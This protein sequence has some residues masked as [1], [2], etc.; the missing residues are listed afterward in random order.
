MD[1]VSGVIPVAVD[2]R[3]WLRVQF[4]F[5]AALIA[6]AARLHSDFE[7]AFCDGRTVTE[8]SDVTDKIEHGDCGLRIADCG[9]R[10]AD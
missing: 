3:A 6:F 9:L 2:A 10:I 8:S 7:D 1:D 5:Q 4:E